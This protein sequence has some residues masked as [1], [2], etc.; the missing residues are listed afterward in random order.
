MRPAD[1]AGGA[2]ADAPDAGDG[3][4]PA[5]GSRYDEMADGYARHW[6]PVLRVAAERVLEHLD[7]AVQAV[8]GPASKDAPGRAARLLDVGAGTGT[9]TRAAITRWPSLH[10]TGIDPSRGM[11]E[12]ARR[13]ADATLP[14]EA[15]ARFE[16]VVAY[17]DELPNSIGTFDAAMSSFV[18]QLVPSRAAALREVRRVLRPGGP[19]AWV[20]WQQSDRHFEP[21]RVANAVLDD[22]GFD[23]PEADSRP[24]D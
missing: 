1:A 5:S 8:A 19:F 9:L 10:V 23:P 14:H 7:A 20:T 12:V 13:L 21:D 3:T 4:G 24:G 15:T 17:A 16:T 2:D 11:L 6:A 22:F 18:L